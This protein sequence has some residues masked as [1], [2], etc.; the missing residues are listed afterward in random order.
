MNVWP[1][2]MATA[3][4][5]LPN[6]SIGWLQDKLPEYLIKLRDECATDRATTGMAVGGDHLFGFAA[7]QVN[8]PLRAAVPY[9]SQQYDGVNG[10][11]GRRW[12]KKQQTD[13]NHL[14]GY[15]RA[16]GGLEFCSESDPR[17]PGERVNLLHKRND[18]MLQRSTVVLAL[19]DP[20][21]ASGG[22]YS[23]IRKAVGAGMPVVL[24]DLQA[25]TVTLPRPENWARRLGTP[26]L[27]VAKP[28]W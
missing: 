21:Q 8:M 25:L 4:R 14:A 9:P 11:P 10:R 27:A 5:R 24:F 7:E 20:E 28:L 15:A 1:E 2:A 17:S 3:H 19:W 23:C 12:T 22:T 16:T 26:A 6:K 18:W 13:W